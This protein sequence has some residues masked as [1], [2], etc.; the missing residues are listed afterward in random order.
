M[1]T[2]TNKVDTVNAPKS[3]ERLE[4][5]STSR[6]IQRKLDEEESDDDYDDDRIHIHTEPID[7]SGFDVLDIDNGGNYV[8]TD[9][10]SLEYEEL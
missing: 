8:M 10:P 5:I 3:L 9:E 2:M 1:D 4:E 6:A 7:L